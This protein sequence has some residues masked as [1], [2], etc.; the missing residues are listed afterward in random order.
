MERQVLFRP[1]W[2]FLILGR[3]WLRGN[4][5][6]NNPRHQTPSVPGA[7]LLVYPSQVLAANVTANTRT[8]GTS[9]CHEQT[10]PTS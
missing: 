1:V 7:S 4:S 8:T 9:N 10:I 3:V 2:H 6:F 5:L